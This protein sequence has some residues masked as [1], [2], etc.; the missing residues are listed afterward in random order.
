MDIIVMLWVSWK[1]QYL[2]LRLFQQ[3]RR[4]IYYTF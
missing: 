4:L 3:P 2:S 1:F